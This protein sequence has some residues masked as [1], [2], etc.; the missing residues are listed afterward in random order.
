MLDETRSLTEEEEKAFKQSTGY[1]SEQGIFYKSSDERTSPERFGETYTDV[2]DEFMSLARLHRTSPWLWARP[3]TMTYDENGNPDGYF[4]QEAP[5]FE[6][7]DFTQTYTSQ[8]SENR[9][10][11]Q[12]DTE[13]V[14]DQVEYMDTLMDIYSQA[15]GDIKPWNIKVDPETSLITGYDP[16]GFDNETASTQEA[17]EEDR[18]EIQ[19]II[20]DL[21]QAS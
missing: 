13:F 2:E 5:G 12:L 11:N 8:A 16:V 7:N 19:K 4:M 9:D 20:S 3:L 21:D 14:R 15:H 10:L 18:K 17:R 6:L 1:E